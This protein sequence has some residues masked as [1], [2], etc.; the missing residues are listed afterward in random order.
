M[1]LEQF[2]LAHEVTLRLSFFVGIFALVALW[3]VLSPQRALVAP[4][5][6]RW[7]SNLGLVVLN[8]VIARLLFPMA[9]VGVAAFCMANG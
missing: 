6:L 7:A 9:A 8:T 2:V 3:E 4:K 1:S 5:G